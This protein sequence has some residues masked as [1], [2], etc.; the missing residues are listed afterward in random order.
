MNTIEKFNEHVM[1]TYGRYDVV[2]KKGSGRTA[3]DE[4]GKGALARIKYGV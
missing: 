1:S 4:D 2:M 3:V